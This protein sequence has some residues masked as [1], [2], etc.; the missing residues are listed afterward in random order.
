MHYYEFTVD[1]PE[2]DV[3]VS[4]MKILGTPLYAHRDDKAVTNQMLMSTL[5][6]FWTYQTVPVNLIL[7][8]TLGKVK[9]CNKGASVREVTSVTVYHN[10]SP[11]T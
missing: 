2:P 3:A 8:T 9:K 7:N 6:I 11:G 5:F 10:H 4:K 1:E